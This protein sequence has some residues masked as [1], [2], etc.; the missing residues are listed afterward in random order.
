MLKDSW[1]SQLTT[2]QALAGLREKLKRWNREVF[3]DVQKRKE[4]LMEEIKKV[5][6]LLEL[7]Q[8]DAL[9]SKE[10]G[11]L[12]EFELVLEQ[13][14]IIWFQKSREK[15]IALGD[16]NTT[17]FHTS[18]IIRRRRN[19]IESLKGDDSSEGFP[20]L[21]REELND[22]G[23]AFSSLDVNCAIKGMG[24]YKAP[25]PDGYQ[26]VFYQSCWEVV[27]E[28]VQRFVLD[29]FA[30]GQLTEGMNDALVVLIAKVGK[31]E[32]MTH[33]RPI[34]LC[35]VLFKT[36]TK[37]L[38]LRMKKVIS[39][40][41]GPAQSSFIP[42]R[43]STDNIVLVQEAVH[44]M[45]RKKGRKGWM[46]LKLDLEKAYDRIRWDFLEDTLTAARFPEKWVSWIMSCVTGPS[47][48]LLWNGE[49]SDSFK[50]LRGLRQGDPLSPYLLVLCLERLCHLIDYSVCSGEWKPISLSRGGPKLSH[51]CFADDLILF[52][53]AS[54]K[55]IR[56]IRRVLERFCV[57]SG[58]KVS[59]EKS[60]IFFSANVSRDMEKLI[61]DESGI[62]STRDL[63]KY[64]GMPV[65]QKRINKETFSDVLEKV[66][67]RLAGWKGRCLSLAGRLT[68]TKAVLA[69]IPIHTMSTILLP[70]STL[71][72]LDKVSQSFLWGSHSG[73]RK[74]HLVNWKKV[75]SRK[76]DGGLGIRASKDMN[77]ALLAKLGWRLIHDQNSLW[78]RVV[79]VP[80]IRWVIG[81]GNHAKFWTEKWLL[82]KPLTEVVTGALPHGVLDLRVCEFWQNGSGWVLDRIEPYIPAQVVLQLRSVVLDNITGSRD[83]ISWGESANGEF[84]VS[85][86]YSL[87]T[88]NSNPRQDMGKLFNRVWHVIAPERV[89]LFIWLGMHQALMT[90]AERQRRH[91]SDSGIC[92]VCRSAEE[93]ILHILR[94]CPAMD[95]VWIRL[96]PAGKRHAFFAKT[97]ME[98]L[99]V[100]LGDDTWVGDSGWSTQFA[101]AI[102]WAWKWRCGNVFGVQGKCRD[103]VKFLKDLAIEVTLAHEKAAEQQ[104]KQVG[105]VEKQIAWLKPAA[106]WVKV[107]TDGASRGNPGL[108]AAGGVLRDETG[109]WCGGFSLNIGVCSAPLA[110]LWGVY[111]GLYIAW[112][113]RATRVELELDSEM[114]VGFLKTGISEYHPL[115]FLV[116]LCHG[117]L[118]RDWIV[119][120]S[121]VYRE[122]NRLADGLANY[123]FSLPLG[124][125]FFEVVPDSVNA[126]LLEDTG[127]TAFPR[128]VRL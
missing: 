127:G 23:K 75:C 69:S 50:P 123:A 15:W 10:A 67:S 99:Y 96:V 92:P 112:E 68:L 9:L 108:A 70:K 39:K 8:T 34:S 49:K 2:P 54:V 116:R 14:E 26:P 83:R 113:R 106:G 79:V 57:A 71:E 124:F 21:T 55:Q 88:N 101:M 42:G 119:R 100:N 118:A 95:G 117:F 17:Y 7:T 121:H 81:D 43:L 22:L 74:Q 20:S 32:Q 35:N 5:Q 105:R 28:S 109:K 48:S 64:L 1:N 25:G 90:N 38:M 29:F 16:R 40:L 76:C 122:A 62:K 65:L 104:K 80:G 97:L 11:L 27:G 30:L 61:S 6:D 63:G 73:Q 128:R 36:I 46:L 56:V 41:I 3:G 33:F 125:R 85:S 77:K 126:I 18:T 91:L 59:L 4:K 89:R 86:A 111:Y 37:V 115:S 94:D 84:T 102:W 107:N 120:I 44:S 98:W 13:E 78:A 87:L 114:V 60:K 82:N 52:A 110:E 93:T 45:R 58:Q 12:E 19:R 103:R 31:P 47:M 72:S 51:I 24:K 66:S 53:E